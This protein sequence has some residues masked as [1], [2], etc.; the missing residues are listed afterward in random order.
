MA[1]YKGFATFTPSER[2]RRLALESFFGSAPACHTPTIRNDQT[3]K[4]SCSFNPISVSAMSCSVS[5]DSST[6]SGRAGPIPHTILKLAISIE[7]DVL[8][9]VRWFADDP[10]FTL[11]GCTAKDLVASGRGQSVV[12]F[13]HKV[14]R[15][16]GEVINQ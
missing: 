8:E 9:V 7:P 3:M 15:S 4:C 12:S 10:I 13:L 16:E 2:Y 5:G 11:G 1:F 6:S 14:K